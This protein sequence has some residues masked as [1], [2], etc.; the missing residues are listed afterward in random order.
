MAG[1]DAGLQIKAG[2]NTMSLF[3]WKV[4]GVVLNFEQISEKFWE[5]RS[6]A[7]DFS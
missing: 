3:A 4:I 2:V 5:A 6:T 1:K 7:K